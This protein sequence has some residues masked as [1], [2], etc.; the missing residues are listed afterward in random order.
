MTRGT[1]PKFTF[2]LDKVSSFKFDNLELKVESPYLYGKHKILG[3]SY[4][5]YVD[6]K[7][8]GVATALVTDDFFNKL[9]IEGSIGLVI[10]DRSSFGINI[11]LN[12]TKAMLNL[13]RYFK[14]EKIL[15]TTE[16]EGGS[17]HQMCEDLNGTRIDPAIS[18]EGKTMI[19]YEIDV[20]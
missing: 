12:V 13:F 16:N 7:E 18:K 9:A 11:P 2:D 15:I 1:E 8:L 20:K 5:V 17:I 6:G 4:L 3:F 14:Q 10:T 19:R